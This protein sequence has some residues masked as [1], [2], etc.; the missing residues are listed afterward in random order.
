MV[1]EV[2]IFLREISQLLKVHPSLSFRS[3][4]SSF[5][6]FM[7]DY[8]IIVFQLSPSSLR[9][10]R[11]ITHGYT[12]LS[13]V[14]Y[15]TYISTLC[16]YHCVCWGNIL[17]LHIHLLGVKWKGRKQRHHWI[18]G[19]ISSHLKSFIWDTGGCN[20]C[21]L[22]D[23]GWTHSLHRVRCEGEGRE[24]CGSQCP[25]CN[26]ANKDWWWVDC[27]KFFQRPTQIAEL[28]KL[29]E[30]LLCSEMMDSNKT[31]FFLT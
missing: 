31:S 29:Q 30:K 12:F 7:R 15:H 1:C 24:C 21:L 10:I 9:P 18:C 20:R 22:H 16:T 19:G 11:L 8:G 6:V 2:G 3:H 27:E 28:F 17:H 14:R 5:P 23:T 25:Q 13:F 4:L 26:L